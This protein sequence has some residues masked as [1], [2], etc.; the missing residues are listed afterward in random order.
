[1]D[2]VNR[3]VLPIIGVWIAWHVTAQDVNE[4]KAGKSKPCHWNNA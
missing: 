3:Y 1:M 4:L 2:L